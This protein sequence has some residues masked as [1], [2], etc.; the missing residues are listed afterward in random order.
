MCTEAWVY[1]VNIS[2]VIPMFVVRKHLTGP[3]VFD[4]LQNGVVHRDLKLENILLD[5]D[6]NVKVRIIKDINCC[7]CHLHIQSVY[8][9]IFAQ[10]V[11]VI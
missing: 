8:W 3:R 1:I 4:V 11:C 6:L 9:C 5:E 7:I 2:S 10:F